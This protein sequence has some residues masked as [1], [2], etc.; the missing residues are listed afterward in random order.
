M[1]VRGQAGDLQ[2]GWPFAPLWCAA[3]RLGAVPSARP[4]P[5]AAIAWLLRPAV[6]AGPRRC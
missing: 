6:V 1:G 4:P 5:G 2:G 3:G